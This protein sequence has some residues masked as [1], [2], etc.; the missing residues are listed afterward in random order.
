MKHFKN[1]NKNKKQKAVVNIEFK[2]SPVGIAK[3]IN[4][5][6]PH[7]IINVRRGK[8]LHLKIYSDDLNDD[9]SFRLIMSPLMKNCP[10]LFR[11][12]VTI[13]N[14]EMVE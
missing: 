8:I 7:V 3:L 1:K 4:R 9:E 2:E 13:K 5:F 12:S 10:E 11:N 14:Y 6:F